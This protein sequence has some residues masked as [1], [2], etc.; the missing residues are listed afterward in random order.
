MAQNVLASPV[1]KGVFSIL[2]EENPASLINIVPT[3]MKE[4]IQRLTVNCPSYI[5]MDELFIR[6][7]AKPSD[8]DER[9]RLS[10]WDAYHIATVEQRRM[11]ITQFINSHTISIEQFIRDYLRRPTVKLAYIIT[12]PRKYGTSMRVLLDKGIRRIEEIMDLP[13]MKPDGTPNTSLIVQLIKTFQMIDMRVKGAIVQKMQIQQQ[14]L[15]INADASDMQAASIDNQLLQ[16]LSSMTMADLENLE[17]K[18]VRLGK[19]E[20]QLTSDLPLEEQIML[21]EMKKDMEGV[22]IDA[23]QEFTLGEAKED[24]GEGQGGDSTDECPDAD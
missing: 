11:I 19:M 21:R 15:N 5:G 4:P 12:P 17:R 1:V 20:K 10:F 16:N 9:I 23:K 24:A 7:E 2:D 8:R 22:T 6:K 14:N 18:M 13:I 3:F